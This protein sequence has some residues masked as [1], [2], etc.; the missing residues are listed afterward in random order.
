MR[1]LVLGNPL[2]DS[3]SLALKLLPSLKERFPNIE[4]EEADPADID[5][6]Q[7]P[8]VIDVAKNVKK[9]VLIDDAKRL[10]SDDALSIHGLGLAE[11]LS[12][13]ETA[14]R[15]VSVKIICV[16]EK[17]SPKLALEKITPMLRAILLSGNG[18][19]R[20]CTGRKRG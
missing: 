8:I 12:L 5:L 4:F 17:M 1:V 9:V 13:M 15:K 3:D 6:E 2:V 11:M 7:D 10:Q 14:G 18:K 16:P 19:R 20:T